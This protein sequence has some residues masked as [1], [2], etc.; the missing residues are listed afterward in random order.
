VP[1]HQNWKGTVFPSV[2]RC[3]KMVRVNVLHKFLVW[4]V[5]V[6]CCHCCTCWC[7]LAP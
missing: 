1:Q 6:F 3:E 4:R 5:C 7:T 2:L